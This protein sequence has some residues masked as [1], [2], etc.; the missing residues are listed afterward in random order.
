MDIIVPYEL[1]CNNIM[2]AIIVMRQFA[3]G[4]NNFKT[5]CSLLLASKIWHTATVS[6]STYV[7]VTCIQRWL[8]K[9]RILLGRYYTVRYFSLLLGY[10]THFVVRALL[11]LLLDLFSRQMRLWENTHRGGKLLKK[12]KII[13]FFLFR[14]NLS[15]LFSECL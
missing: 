8:S 5:I 9:I 14:V 10:K 7:D 13:F 2:W 15:C 1:L 3:G 11:F 6:Y 4:K 12:E